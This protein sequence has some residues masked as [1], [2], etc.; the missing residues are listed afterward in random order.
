MTQ[1]KKK[2]WHVLQIYLEVGEMLSI[3]K[4]SKESQLRYYFGQKKAIL[5]RICARLAISRLDQ[6]LQT[7]RMVSKISH[8]T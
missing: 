6:L 2:V 3:V 8:N 1:K 5:L 4:E 7:H